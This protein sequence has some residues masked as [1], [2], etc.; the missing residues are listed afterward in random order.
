MALSQILVLIRRSTLEAPPIIKAVELMVA[1]GSVVLGVGTAL[2]LGSLPPKPSDPPV[3]SWLLWGVLVAGAVLLFVG[4]VSFGLWIVNGGYRSYRYAR[5]KAESLPRIRVVLDRPGSVSTV[6][7]ATV[8]EW[9]QGGVEVA[10]PQSTQAL[11]DDDDEPTYKGK[12]QTIY[13]LGEYLKAVDRAKPYRERDPETP[14]IWSYKC[15]FCDYRSY[16]DQGALSMLIHIDKKHG[17]STDDEAESE[18]RV[19]DADPPADW[20]GQFWRGKEI[21]PCAWD[22]YRTTSNENWNDHLETHTDPPTPQADKETSL[23]PR[24]W[25][26][27][28]IHFL[29]DGSRTFPD[30][31]A[32]PDHTIYVTEKYANELAAT[33]LY[34]LGPVQKQEHALVDAGPPLRCKCGHE[35]KNTAWFQSHL[36]TEKAIG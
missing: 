30:V 17:D 33:G 34:A 25:A 8:R 32:D 10:T 12:A 26:K 4:L 5:S 1:G 11:A 3:W 6:P 20:T 9:G 36:H 7:V 28:P 13:V 27:H 35:A 16:T 15:P 23:V 14:A 2:G 21:T 31:P 18:V 22:N 19:D 24:Q 29:G